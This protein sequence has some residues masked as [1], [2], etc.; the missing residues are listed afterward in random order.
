M[1]EAQSASE[2]RCLSSLR[3]NIFCV[4]L[5]D[6]E[7]KGKITEYTT[8]NKLTIKNINKTR[9]YLPSPR[10]LLEGNR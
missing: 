5:K 4:N 9:D 3:R 1:R 10:S 2:A 7:I 6:Y 8:N